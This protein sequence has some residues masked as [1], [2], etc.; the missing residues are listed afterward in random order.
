MLLATLLPSWPPPLWRA[1]S[2]RL[3]WPGV[4]LNP[5]VLSYVAGP[6]ATSG[7][8]QLLAT[9]IR[10][11][12]CTFATIAAP[13]GSIGKCFQYSMYARTRRSLRSYQP[14]HCAIKTLAYFSSSDIRGAPVTENAE[15]NGNRLQYSC[16]DNSMDRG[17]WRATVCGGSPWGLKES[18]V[19]EQ[20]H[21]HILTNKKVIS[22]NNNNN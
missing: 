2:P 8:I 13:G 21:M 22:I 18:D 9:Q 1:A 14:H 4:C 16:L 12:M 11:E 20:L 5:S 19:T 7:G 10:P 6:V 17:A 3:Q 15:G